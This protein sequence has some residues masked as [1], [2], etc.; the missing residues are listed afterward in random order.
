MMI[1]PAI[2]LMNGKVVRLTQGDASRRSEYPIK[3]QEAVDR[4]IREGAEMIHIVDLDAALGI[5]NNRSIIKTIA[6][7]CS[8]PLQVGGGIRD[9]ATVSDLLES[10][11]YRVI[12]GSLVFNNPQMARNLIKKYTS[13]RVVVSLDHKRSEIKVNGWK[14]S[15]GIQLEDA[16][17][18][19]KP[20]KIEW[21]QITDIE[22]D[23]T[24]AGP[25]IENIRTASRSFRV[26]AGGGIASTG[27]IEELC[28]A[29]AS[30]AVIG[31]ALYENRFTLSEA[32]EVAKNAC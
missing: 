6:S 12:L 4:W 8:I 10:G 14:T 30:A 18:T 22:R 20:L 17:T 31:K 23:G 16:L 9:V 25:D 32:L 13:D 29:G 26:I 1:I 28:E 21:V 2:D 27:D 5:G 3:P 15:A 24:F 19:L 7:E 11:L